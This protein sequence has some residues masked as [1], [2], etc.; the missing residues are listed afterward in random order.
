MKHKAFIFDFDG[1]LVHSNKIK[2]DAFYVLTPEIEQHKSVVDKVLSAISE[3]S[4]FEIIEKIYA[5]IEEVSGKNY[6][7]SRVEHAINNYSIAVRDG[8]LAC[9]E[10]DGASRLLT[11][12][13]EA[14]R[15]VYISSNTP[16]ASLGELIK[17]RN[18]DTLI[19][20][21]YGFPKLKTDTVKAIMQD[22]QLQRFEI[23]VVGDGTSDEISA[24]E[25]GCDFYKIRSDKS[26]FDFY[27]SFVNSDSYV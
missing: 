23:I 16:E 11:V 27:N 15:I 22:H 18:W 8:V 12:L 19:H 25:N 26:L 20:G 10:L 9:P 6:P 17:G 1:T 13:H 24:I 5:G 7:A 21:Y 2:R 14:G 4:R 3:K